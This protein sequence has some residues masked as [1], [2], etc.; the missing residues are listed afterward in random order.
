V[1][2]AGFDPGTQLAFASCGQ[3]ATVIIAK[4]ES[5]DKLTV[6]QTLKTERGARTMALD[7][8]THKIYLPTAKFEP[9]VEGERRPRIIPGTF[10]I[11]VYGM[12]ESPGK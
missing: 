5:P 2:G 9:P 11:L 10:K 1:D 12:E 8:T 6:I 3:S 4:E 7:P